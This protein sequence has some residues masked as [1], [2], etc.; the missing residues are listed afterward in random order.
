[1]TSIEVS[2]MDD[3][4]S[5]ANEQ[6]AKAF[7]IFEMMTWV[8]GGSCSSIGPC[9]APTF[10]EI[11]LLTLPLNLNGFLTTCLFWMKDSCLIFSSLTFNSLTRI[12]T[13]LLPMP[14][15]TPYCSNNLVPNGL[16]EYVCS[17]A[18]L[19]D[20]F[21]NIYQLPNVM[22]P[23]INVLGPFMEHYILW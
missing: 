1:M 21:S 10:V 18:L 14:R 16:L 6:N 19:H 11:I 22:I 23:C 9:M 7:G 5:W 20:D 17:L 12:S 3:M 2:N 13:S 15:L 8:D 4:T